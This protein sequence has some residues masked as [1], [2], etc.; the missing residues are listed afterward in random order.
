[1]IDSFFGSMAYTDFQSS[2][3]ECALT[4]VS[5]S[6]VEYGTTDFSPALSQAKAAETRLFVL[7]LD[8][9]AMAGQL[10]EQGF[11]AGLFREGTA[12]LG[13]DLITTPLTWQAIVN[14]KNIPY[15]MKG[16]IG[17]QYSPGLGMMT[18]PHGQKFISN[19]I[20]QPSTEFRRADGTI[21]CR[22][23]SL[24]DSGDFFLY[25]LRQNSKSVCGG[26]DFSLFNSSG[27]NIYPFAAHVYDAVYAVAYAVH[28]L[29]VVENK[30]S[31]SPTDFYS[32]LLK[33]TNFDG[34]SGRV[35]FTA[36]SSFY[37]YNNRGNREVGHDYL[38]YQFNEGL[39]ST[40][41][42]GTGA[43]GVI[44]MFH[45]NISHLCSPGYQFLNGDLCYEPTFNTIDGS[46][47][48]NENVNL[49]LTFSTEVCCFVLAGLLFSVA[50][51]FVFLTYRF[52]SYKVIHA[53]Q[54][55][56]IYFVLLGAI[57][58]A[59]RILIIGL[60][61]TDATCIAK[62]WIGHVAF[63]VLFG[64]LLR[65]LWKEFRVIYARRVRSDSRVFDKYSS[66]RFSPTRAASIR[67]ASSRYSTI[68]MLKK[69]SLHMSETA[70]QNSSN[71]NSESN[72]GDGGP[73]T[74][75]TALKRAI[76][77]ADNFLLYLVEFVVVYLAVATYFGRPYSSFLTQYFNL[78]TTH[79]YIC[80]MQLPIFD[81]VLYTVE[82]LLLLTGQMMILFLRPYVDH[83]VESRAN[84]MAIFF[85]VMIIFICSIAAFGLDSAGLFT[86]DIVEIILAVA[87]FVAV[88]IVIFL[89]CGPPF[90]LI[91]SIKHDGLRIHEILMDNEST[92]EELSEVIATNK[93]LMYKRDRYGQNA[94]R[95]ALEFN[96]SDDVLL[97][98]IH[99]FLP[100]DP[101]TKE[102]I[103]ADDHG[104]AWLSLVQKDR[105]AELV[106]KIL[107]KYASICIELANATD[108][109]GRNAVN[110]ASQACQRIIREST[111][112]CKRY[113]ITTLE[114]PVHLSRS[115]VVHLALDH[116]HSGEKVALKLMKNL[117]QYTREVAVRKEARLSNEFTINILRTHDV[118]IHDLYKEEILRRGWSEYLYCIVMPCA[119]RD[120]NRIITNEH[121]AGKEWGQVR[122]IAVEIAQA[123][124]HMHSN[125]VIHGDVKSKN[126]MRIGHRVKL[127]DFDASVT[128][129]KDYVGAKY[130]SAFV[131]PEMI[132]FKEQTGNRG[133]NSPSA[134]SPSPSSVGTKESLS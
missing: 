91:L 86:E 104:Y 92:E 68:N 32:T 100:F 18:S 84:M 22:S 50:S 67:S 71:M 134:A 58:C 74:P 29:F 70:S 54:R 63:F 21:S 106:E 3:S 24:D 80:T 7:L 65:Q 12:I 60:S 119:D 128:I 30:T 25:S 19:F 64:V 81:S 9:P 52:R 87:A 35:A 11:N 112:F 69:S 75:S 95:V 88:S 93:A 40:T 125:G 42:N 48:V 76:K 101:E 105:N 118:T 45:S 85:S 94:F 61:V 62:M 53:N 108:N 2:L 77:V 96:V 102:P 109:E 129:G 20:Q 72:L 131:P 56:M 13:T 34:A 110:I 98:L 97:E 51:T 90:Y 89:L 117:D 15:I 46:T 28:Q 17:L 33:G 55:E 107:Q 124:Q 5:E 133:R 83:L 103:P 78:K 122:A 57:L 41:T 113:E 4:V 114:A 132:Y 47:P 49:T 8:Q 31:L 16:F 43:F 10:L 111:Y 6:I 23:N 82:G 130:S 14:K 27:A 99:Y 26:L 73:L 121:I 36:G 120:L 1:M 115:C 38:I 44:G 66:V 127:I 123:L 39:Y 59:V 79:E 116:R 126:I 37:P